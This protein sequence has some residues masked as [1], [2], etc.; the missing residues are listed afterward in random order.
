MNELASLFFA[1]GATV[2]C[3]ETIYAALVVL[4]GYIVL[5]ISGFGSALTIVPMLAW[6]WPLASVV[7]LVLLLDTPA[8]VLQAR[9]N[10]THIAWPEIK[11]LI[12]GLFAGAA[13]GI[14]MATWTS[15][16]WALFA[17]G[18]YVVAAAAKKSFSKGK[19]HFGG[20]LGWPAC[21]GLGWAANMRL[22]GRDGW[23]VRGLERV[24]DVGRLHDDRLLDLH[25]PLPQKR[26][27]RRRVGLSHVSPSVVQESTHDA[28][29][30][31]ELPHHRAK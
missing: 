29:G 27:L 20:V 19:H 1:A 13:L 26:P 22:R 11:P 16:P 23:P 15:Q 10:N 2:S 3:I 4:L 25:H 21:A 14:W 24:V 8:S 30:D 7:P 5:G 9:L 12:P 31:F 6:N 28:L 17:L 18:V